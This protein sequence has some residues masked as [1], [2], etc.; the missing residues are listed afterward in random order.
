VRQVVPLG[1]LRRALRFRWAVIIAVLLPAAVLGVGAVEIRTAPAVA[2]SVVGVGPETAELTNADT[3]RLALGRYA[4]LLTSSEALTDISTATGVDVDTLETAVEIVVSQDAGNLAVRVTMPAEE[5]AT[6]VAKAVADYAVAIGETDL[7]ANAAVLS[8]ARAEDPGLLASKR[9]LQAAILLAAL[10]LAV[11]AAYLLELTRGRI[12]TGGDAAEAVGGPLLGN[13]PVLTSTRFRRVRVASDDAIRSSARSLRSG[14]AETDRS[15]PPGPVLVVGTEAGAGATTVA[16]LLARTLTD[17]GAATLVLDLDL[18]G[19]GLTRRVGA[20]GGPLL[21]DVLA[22][23]CSLEEATHLEGGVGVLR[24]EPLH[25]AD[26][27][28]DRRLP[29]LLALAAKTW[30]V[31]LCDTTPLGA[32]E[33][34]EIVAPHATSA[35]V[36]VPLGSPRAGAERTAARLARLGIPVRG[37]V[38]NGASREAA[39]AAGLVHRG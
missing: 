27:L 15:V 33:I 25:G 11:G 32:G 39:E 10:V 36:V 38:L 23:R 7:D 34:S 18:D 21:T 8:A 3:V 5:Q 29:D 37:V 6:A 14:W 19:A 22:E 2:V 31:V 28:V 9:V 12:R 26:D 24:T 17:R 35:V 20:D 30:D 4:V 13:L 1:V 16:Y